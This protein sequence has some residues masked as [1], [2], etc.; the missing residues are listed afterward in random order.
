MDLHNT[1]VTSDHHFRAWAH[2]G[3]VLSESTKEEEVQHIAL[4]NSVVG[5]DSL[6]LYVGDFCHWDYARGGLADLAVVRPQLNGRIVLIRL[7]PWR[8]CRPCGCPSAAERAD[9]SHQRQSR[10]A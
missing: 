4:W 3:G 2:F 6:V 5:K 10:H 9:R 7:R 8:A 1:F